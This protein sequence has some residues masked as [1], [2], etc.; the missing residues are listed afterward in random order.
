MDSHVL[1]V[2]L[3]SCLSHSPTGSPQDISRIPMEFF[4]CSIFA[5]SHQESPGHPKDSQIWQLSQ[6]PVCPTVPPGVLRTSQVLPPL[7]VVPVSRLSHSPTGS[8][9][10]IPKTPTLDSCSS[11]LSVPQSHWESPR[12][13]KDPTGT[14]KGPMS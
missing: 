5:P 4:Q 7:V 9:Q 13:P 6:C 8:P 10:D 2:G 14:P 3:V 12:H 11:V 1:G